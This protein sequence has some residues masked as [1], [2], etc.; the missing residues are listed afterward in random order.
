MRS[1]REALEP[2]GGSHTNA[3]QKRNVGSTFS[4]IAVDRIP[5]DERFP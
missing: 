1:W 3:I 5:T 2:R 4:R